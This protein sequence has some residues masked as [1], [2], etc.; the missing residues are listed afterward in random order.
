MCR[1]LYR[2]LWKLY[3]NRNCIMANSYQNGNFDKT[4]MRMGN[5]IE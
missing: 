1:I 3:M 2:H 4:E 5:S